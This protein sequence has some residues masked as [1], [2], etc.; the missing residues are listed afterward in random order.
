MKLIFIPPNLGA[1]NPQETI[2][3]FLR[4]GIKIVDLVKSFN[5]VNA[6][7]RKSLEREGQEFRDYLKKSREFKKIL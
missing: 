3:Y 1:N 6:R 5:N 7:N 4:N 2:D